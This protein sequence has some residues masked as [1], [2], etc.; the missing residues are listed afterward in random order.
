MFGE[1]CAAVGKAARLS[2]FRTSVCAGTR[3]GSIRRDTEGALHPFI[4]ISRRN[5]DAAEYIAGGQAHFDPAFHGPLGYTPLGRKRLLRQK[6]SLVE[7]DAFAVRHRPLFCRK[8]VRPRTTPLPPDANTVQVS[9]LQVVP[10][11]PRLEVV[12]MRDIFDGDVV[13]VSVSHALEIAPED[14]LPKRGANFFRNMI[15]SWSHFRPGT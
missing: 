3:S 10:N 5:A 6:L 7:F 13:C 4:S 15:V 8:D 14:F 12:V 11:G 9:V 2:G 1:L